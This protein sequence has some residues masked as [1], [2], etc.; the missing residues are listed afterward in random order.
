M[1]AST[2]INKKLLLKWA[3]SIVVSII[4]LFVATNDVY[5]AQIQ[6]FLVFTLLGICL[7]AFEL[8]NGFAVSFLMIAGWVLTGVTDFAGAMTSFTTTNFIMIVTAMVF[9]NV[10][11]LRQVF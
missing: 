4:P 1:S 6:H 7:L 2:S 8:L 11:I 9:V 5:T 10:I 3:I